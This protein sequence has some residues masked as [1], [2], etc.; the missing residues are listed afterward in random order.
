M[1]DAAIQSQLAMELERIPLHPHEHQTELR[2]AFILQ[3]ERDLKK[4]GEN[5]SAVHALHRAVK[6]VREKFPE[7][8]LKFD[9]V[10]FGSWC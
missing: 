5:Y 2:M 1:T 4:H 10:Y 7:A 6:E 8:L 3:R 9:N